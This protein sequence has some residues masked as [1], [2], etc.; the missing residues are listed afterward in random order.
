MSETI[1]KNP[2]STK[3]V[4]STK[5][6]KQRGRKG[7]KVKNAFRA[8]PTEPVSIDTFT[9]E[10]NVSVHCLKQSKRFDTTGLPGKVHVKKDKTSGVTMIW[11][12]TTDV[13]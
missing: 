5:V 1:H 11:R 2:S 12:E 3:P 7:D 13:E 10:H 4:T 9:Q 6:V 8:I